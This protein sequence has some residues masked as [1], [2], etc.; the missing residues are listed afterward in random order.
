MPDNIGLGHLN[1][2]NAVNA[3]E[4]TEGIVQS[5]ID[6]PRQVDLGE[7]KRRPDTEKKELAAGPKFNP[8]IKIY[9]NPTDGCIFPVPK[10]GNRCSKD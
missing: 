1:D 10:S 6:A 2:R 3:I 8:G 7:R 9:P 5:A 4:P